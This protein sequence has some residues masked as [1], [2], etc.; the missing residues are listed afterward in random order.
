[1]LDIILLMQIEPSSYLL[2]AINLTISGSIMLKLGYVQNSADK[3]TAVA[4]TPNNANVS[5]IT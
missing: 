3:I 4:V 5:F 2:S 1:M